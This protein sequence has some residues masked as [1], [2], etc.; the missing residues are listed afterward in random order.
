MNEDAD[1]TAR[2]A[3]ETRMNVM[4]PEMLHIISIPWKALM[5]CRPI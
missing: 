4:V 2:E 1:P 5:I 3:F